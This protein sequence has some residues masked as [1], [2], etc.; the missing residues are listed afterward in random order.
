M[1]DPAEK[2]TEVPS[3]PGQAEVAPGV[4]LDSRLG[5]FHREEGW[6]AVSDL[7]FGYEVSRRAAGGL[8]PMWGIEAVET[9]LK[10]L[11]E[12]LRP[13]TLILNG[14]IVDSSAAPQEA[15]CWLSGLQATVPELI[16]IEGNHD[17]GAIR[18]QF[19]FVSHYRQGPFF[20][21]H[22]HR[23]IFEEE[24]I[25]ETGMIEVTGHAHPTANFN[26]GAG[27]SLRLPALAV[28]SF[29]HRSLWTLPAFSPWAGGGAYRP[30]NASHPY[31]LW[32]CSEFR[33]F[34]AIAP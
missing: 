15:A 3:R 31:R 5:L 10:M 14:D 17:R 6:L 4:L 28:E 8:W 32:A 22:G 1:I 25:V 12:E 23:P 21:H 9:R 29:P 16:L 24:A 19:P 20:F 34:E 11:I 13:E 26:D 27:T 33:V 7:H 30:I 2:S 18:R